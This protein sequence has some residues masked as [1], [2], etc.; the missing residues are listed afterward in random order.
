MKQGS[1]FAP[2]RPACLAAGRRKG[3]R[4]NRLKK[5]LE[6]NLRE[7][8]VSVVNISSRETP[9]KLKDEAWQRSITP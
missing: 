8:C 6:E 1:E 7:L 5:Q 2:P 9:K 4:E 3:R